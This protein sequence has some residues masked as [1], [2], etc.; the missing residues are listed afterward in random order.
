LRPEI[1]VF[2]V[3]TYK[4]GDTYSEFRKKFLKRME[5]EFNLKKNYDE[6]VR[7]TSKK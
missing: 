6:L 7:L 2:G 4:P 1:S 3:G 5:R